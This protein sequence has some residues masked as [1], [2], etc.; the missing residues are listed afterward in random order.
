MLR[1]IILLPCGITTK[2]PVSVWTFSW[3]IKKEK[4]VSP[5]WYYKI[6]HSSD[7]LSFLSRLPKT[8]RVFGWEEGERQ[9]ET[10]RRIW[11]TRGYEGGEELRWR[12]EEWEETRRWGSREN[13]TVEE[14]EIEEEWR[15]QCRGGGGGGYENRGGVEDVHVFTFGR[16]FCH[17]I[18]IYFCFHHD[19]ASSYCLKIPSWGRRSFYILLIN[20]TTKNNKCTVSPI[21]YK[22]IVFTLK[23]FSTW[24]GT[25][26]ALCDSKTA[27]R[28]VNLS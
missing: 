4:N 11:K 8:A 23:M 10:T 18:F 14:K 20:S 7:C 27:M 16:R 12:W 2:Y 15:L 6:L 19:I 22:R 25:E 9:K 21:E 1:Q 24:I 28:S 13:E 17:N 3:L 26:L 5:T